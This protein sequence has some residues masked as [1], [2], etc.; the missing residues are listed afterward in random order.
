MSDSNY[1]CKWRIELAEQICEKVKVIEGVKAIV[2]GG[3]VGRGY[4]DEYSDLEILIFWDEYPDEITRKLIVKKLNA[5]YFYPYNNYEGREDNVI[6]NGFRIDL[7]HLTLQQ[8]EQVI[9]SITEN[10]E[11]DLGSSNAMDTI[12]TCIPLFGEEIIYS[13]KNR[14]KEYPNAIAIKNIKESLNGIDGTQV[15]LY[16]ERQNS[17]LIYENISNLQKSIFLIFL[18][19]NKQYFPTFKWMYKSFETLKIK[20]KNIE[21]RFRDIFTYPPRKAYDNTLSIMMETL[22]IINEIYPEID[23]NVVLGKLKSA[24]IPH[25]NPVNIL[26]NILFLSRKN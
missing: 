3:S 6:A 20:P 9:K 2:I 7:W 12:R 15:E 17:T 5:E 19:L 13:W 24:R 25:D 21:Q 26:G 10:F 16:L 14:A 23:T 1:H 22:D 18:A 4:A 11:I 8:E